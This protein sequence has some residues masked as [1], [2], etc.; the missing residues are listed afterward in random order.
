MFLVYNI[1]INKVLLLILLLINGNY[2]VSNTYN[3]I[4]IDTISKKKVLRERG[5][6][7]GGGRRTDR[8]TNRE[9][10]RQKLKG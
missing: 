9:K 2:D 5:R 7:K 3:K 1:A 10:D 6:E 4:N 8:E